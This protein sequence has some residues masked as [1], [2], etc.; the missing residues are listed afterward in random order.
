[1]VVKEPK[2]EARRGR[3]NVGRSGSQAERVSQQEVSTGSNCLFYVDFFKNMF[4]LLSHHRV[5]TA[6]D[7]EMQQVPD[8]IHPCRVKCCCYPSCGY[9]SGGR[10]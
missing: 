5:Q 2:N 6:M 4:C 10:F 3:S 1:M 8:E 9:L 7:L